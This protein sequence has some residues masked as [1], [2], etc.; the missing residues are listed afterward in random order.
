MTS[1]WDTLFNI[2]SHSAWE[3]VVR[4][5]EWG[6]RFIVEIEGDN[7]SSDCTQKKKKTNLNIHMSDYME[8]GVKKMNVG[9]IS[10]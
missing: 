6:V 3:E 1:A 5:K 7:M 8:M 9:F 4:I 10:G 2:I